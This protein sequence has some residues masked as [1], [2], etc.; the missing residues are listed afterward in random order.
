MK[1]LA[2]T[3]SILVAALV[4]FLFAAYMGV[5]AGLNSWFP[6]ISFYCALVVIGWLSWFHFFYPKI[7]AILL[8]IFLILMFSSW[9]AFLLVERITGEYKPSLWESLIPLGLISIAI[10]FVW[11]GYYKKQVL[12]KYL[13]Y[14]LAIPPA[15]LALYAGGY[16]TII[17]F[18]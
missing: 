16:F 2:Y 13:K 10:Y 4:Y 1:I 11:M 5:S 6:L 8:T 14:I 17:Y 15:L 3:T 12:N 18:G 7:G 9:P